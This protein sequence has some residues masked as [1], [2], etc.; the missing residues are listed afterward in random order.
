MLPN[1]IKQSNWNDSQAHVE[2]DPCTAVHSAN[3]DL[4]HLTGSFGPPTMC[5]T[6]ASN[7]ANCRLRSSCLGGE[8][9]PLPRSTTFVGVAFG[10]SPNPPGAPG[11]SFCSRT[12]SAIILSG[13]TSHMA[14]TALSGIRK[15]SVGS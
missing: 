3:F 7:T 5:A 9:H 12:I 11:P 8:A 1:L 15:P 13:T 6:I 4:T 2:L 14:F 10:G